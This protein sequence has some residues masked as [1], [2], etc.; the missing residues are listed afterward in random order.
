MERTLIKNLFFE[1]ILT[2][3][4]HQTDQVLAGFSVSEMFALVELAAHAPLSQQMLANHLLLEKS[5]V[6]RLNIC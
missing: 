6:S 2:F 3:G 4:L 5:T 1:L